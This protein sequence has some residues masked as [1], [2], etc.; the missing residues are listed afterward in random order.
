MFSKSFLCSVQV[1]TRIRKLFMKKVP[2]LCFR[3]FVARIFC[4]QAFPVILSYIFNRTTCQ[5]KFDIWLA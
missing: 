5:T 3:K 2:K 1:V 4:V